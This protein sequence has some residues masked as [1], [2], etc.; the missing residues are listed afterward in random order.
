MFSF[1]LWIG[2]IDVN[3]NL[4]LCAY[5]YGQGPTIAAAHTKND[6]FPGPLKIDGTAS[7]DA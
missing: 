2:G 4:K 6:F 3:N 5:R 7:V 1:S